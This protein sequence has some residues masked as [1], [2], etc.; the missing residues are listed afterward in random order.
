MDFSSP[1]ITFKDK[2]L[3]CNMAI[4]RSNAK[5]NRRDTNIDL[6]AL[7]TRTHFPVRLNDM[8]DTHTHTPID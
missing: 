2:L 6:H 1:Y 7:K 8:R 4:L 5:N 3:M